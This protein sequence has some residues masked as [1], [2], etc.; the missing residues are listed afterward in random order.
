MKKTLAFF[1]LLLGCVVMFA[2]SGPTFPY[3]AVV[4]NS[5]NQLIKDSTFAV[6]VEIYQG[7]TLKYSETQ[8]ATTN[9]NGPFTMNIGGGTAG[10]GT[11]NDVADWS[12]AKF[13]ITYH[14]SGGDVVSEQLVHPVPYALQAANVVE[15]QVLTLSNDTIYLT[16]G[17]YVKLPD[18]VLTATMNERLADT[19]NQYTLTSQLCEVVNNCDLTGNAS[20]MAILNAM[21]ARIDSLAHIVDS[22]SRLPHG[23]TPTAF[24]CGTDSVKDADNNWYHTV[25]IGEQCWMK[26]NLRTNNVNGY[27][28]V[29]TNTADG[30]DVNIY[31]RLYD[32]TAVMQDAPSADSIGAQGICPTGWHVPS[33]AEWKQMERAVDLTETEISNFYLRG[34]IAAKICG[35]TG[36]LTSSNPAAA[37]NVSAS[38]RNVSGFSAL[39][40]GRHHNSEC[41]LF[42]SYAY[43]WCAT[44]YSGDTTKAYARYLYY[45][46]AGI[47]RMRYEKSEGF[48]VRCVRN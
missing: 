27:G 34:T 8:S 5:Q 21:D 43:F 44:E 30:Y 12:V 3:Q 42:T 22:L 10:A 33:D 26:E 2:Q 41:D 1:T 20:L 46:D 15:E 6:D 36:W 40:A 35:D 13:K 45:T 48:S 14:L 28:N 16:G 23:G 29:Y 9:A 25:Q 24:T 31:G 18:Y 39:P 4:R 17:S 19:L 37:G 11:L 47:G 38:D 32:W 7:T